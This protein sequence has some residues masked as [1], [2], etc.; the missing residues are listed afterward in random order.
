[1]QTTRFTTLFALTFA[2]FFGGCSKDPVPDADLITPPGADNLLQL[3][4]RPPEM[5]GIIAEIQAGDSVRPAGSTGAPDSAVSCPPSCGEGVRLRN[6]LIDELP[7]QQ[8]YLKVRA[9]AL[10]GATIAE[11]VDGELRALGFSDLRAGMEVD[12]WFDGPVA[13]SYPGQGTLKALVVVRR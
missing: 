4:S 1:M 3:P 7:V 9:T 2:A 12:V 13:E 11:R 5:R 8:G 10:T 6:V